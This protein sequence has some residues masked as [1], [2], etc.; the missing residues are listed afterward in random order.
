MSN[1]LQSVIRLQELD[2]QI[3]SLQGWI[4]ALPQHLREIEKQLSDITQA[5]QTVQEKITVN[6]R[7]RKQHETDI[8]A[9]EQKISKYNNQ[10]LEVKTNDEYRAFLK[11][12][13][14]ARTE[15]RKIEDKILE[16]MIASEGNEKHLRETEAEIKRQR[17]DVAK[18]QEEA[19]ATSRVKQQELN[20]LLEDRQQVQSCLDEDVTDLYNRTAKLRDGIVVAEVRNQMCMACH[21]MLRPQ[22][23]IEVMRNSDIIQCSNCSRI[24]YCN[25][26]AEPAASLKSIGDTHHD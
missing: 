17:Q 10:L 1:E 22:T 9:L 13:E 25:S 12:I 11:E 21:V 6:Q 5:H 19:E 16:L 20:A 24:L 23:Y 26:P 7:Q 2:K 14:Y 15:I 4:S 3:A 18:E 8:Q